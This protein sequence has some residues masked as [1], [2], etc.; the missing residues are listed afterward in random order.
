MATRTGPGQ[1][2]TMVPMRRQR[3]VV[4]LRLGSKIVHRLLMAMTAGARV[5]EAATTTSSPIEQGA[6]RV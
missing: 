1:R 6:P 2:T 5:S 3:R 4:V